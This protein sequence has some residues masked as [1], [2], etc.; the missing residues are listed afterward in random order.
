MLLRKRKVYIEMPE[1]GGEGMSLLAQLGQ[2]IRLE[3][4]KQF[5]QSS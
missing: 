4:K 2:L 1:K 5:G 3:K